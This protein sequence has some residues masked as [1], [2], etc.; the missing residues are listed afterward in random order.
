MKRI[1]LSTLIVAT[2]CSP[3][4]AEPLKSKADRDIAWQTLALAATNLSAK[5]HR[6]NPDTLGFCQKEIN[7]CVEAV[8][9]V[10]TDKKH[11]MVREVYDPN[12]KL[13]N[14][15]VCDYNLAQNERKCEDFDTGIYRKEVK[16]SNSS[17]VITETVNPGI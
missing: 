6:G 8:T 15:E 1:I 9:Y 16:Y 10:G 4:F 2:I 5:Q 7:K 3:A 11:H 14:R 17:W 13:I 12:H